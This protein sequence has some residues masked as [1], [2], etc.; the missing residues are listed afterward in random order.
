MLRQS[1]NPLNQ[2]LALAIQ[3]NDEASFE[4]FSWGDNGL[5]KDQLSNILSDSPVERLLYFWGTP[6]CGKSHLLQAC[7]QSITTHQAIYLP[8]KTLASLGAELIGGI[9]DYGLICIDD[10]DA[11]AGDNSWEEALFHLY[12]RIRDNGIARLI[13]SGS[14]PPAQLPIKLADLRSRLTW[15][16]TIQVEELN[17]DD[18]IETL[19]RHAQKRGFKLPVGVARFLINRCSRNMHDL[20]DLLNKL[21]EAS[22]VAQ[23]KLTVPFVK[24]VLGL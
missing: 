19:S 9:D 8:L 17:D 21:D 3:L 11:I 18:K 2:Q 1:S 7:C 16:M 4:D 10:I 6:A 12:N 20:D 22:L 15:G 14:T 24:N 23:R 13:V 5:L